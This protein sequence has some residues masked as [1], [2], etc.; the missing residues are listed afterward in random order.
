MSV[1]GVVLFWRAD[2]GQFSRAPKAHCATSPAEGKCGVGAMKLPLI[3]GLFP[4]LLVPTLLVVFKSSLWPAVLAY[5]ALCVGIP[6]A[7]RCSFRR[8]GLVLSPRS[9]ALSVMLSVLGLA[10]VG[11]G[12]Q[13]I[14]FKA[15]LPPGSE[16]ALLRLQP[17]W[18]FVV[19]SLLVNPFSEEYFWRGFLLPHTGVAVGALLFWLM[20]VTAGAVFIAPLDAVWLTLPALGAGWAWGLMRERLGT[21]WPSVITHVAADMAVLWIAF[22]LVRAR[23]L[24]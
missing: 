19:Y 4:A 6:L 10:A 21:L 9:I 20:H 2:P 15:I 12:S 5:H 16:V 3:L 14:D 24:G 13:L 18:G 23:P 22:D 8:A 11:A 17:W 7:A 1:R